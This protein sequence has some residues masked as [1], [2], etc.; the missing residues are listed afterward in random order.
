[1]TVIIYQLGFALDTSTGRFHVV[2][3]ASMDKK[4]QN[5]ARARWNKQKG[6][7]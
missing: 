1:M 3:L 5:G 4:S 7:K 6:R 2:N